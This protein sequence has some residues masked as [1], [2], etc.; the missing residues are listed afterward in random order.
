MQENKR[1]WIPLPLST[2]AVVAFRL[3][4]SPLDRWDQNGGVGGVEAIVDCGVMLLR[5]FGL[6]LTDTADGTDGTCLEMDGGEKGDL[7]DFPH[8]N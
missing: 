8:C 5:S 6:R 3:R 4:C 1:A 2:L 7:L